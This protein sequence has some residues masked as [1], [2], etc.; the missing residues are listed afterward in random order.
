M[1][2]FQR[3]AGC[4]ETADEKQGTRLGVAVRN[5]FERVDAD[6]R[7]PL[8]GKGIRTV[9]RPRTREC[10]IFHELEWYRVS[11]SYVSKL[12]GAGLFYFMGYALAFP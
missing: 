10:M 1:I 5:R 2:G 4:C 6:G 3:A 12:R 7:P 8:P 9:N 11:M